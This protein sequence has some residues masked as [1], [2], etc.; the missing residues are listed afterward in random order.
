MVRGA[1]EG[2]CKGG[3][4]FGHRNKSPGQL[5]GARLIGSG[6]PAV[7][8]PVFL[9]TGFY[10][11][12][13]PVLGLYILEK[14]V[15][16]GRLNPGI[17]ISCLVPFFIQIVGNNNLLLHRPIVIAV[18]HQSHGKFI[19]R[20]GGAASAGFQIAEEGKQRFLGQLHAS[21]VIIMAAAE[22][23]V[24]SIMLTI[25]NQQFIVGIV[26]LHIK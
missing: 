10:R 5:I 15:R 4:R 12:H 11:N 13:V 7:V 3:G 14:F 23:V 24:F 6:A 9:C 26:A 1:G 25:K 18:G 2:R 19:V 17:G 21:S 22:T 16:E 20:I 8:P